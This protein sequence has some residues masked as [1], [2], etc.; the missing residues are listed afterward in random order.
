[1]Q[2]IHVP[3]LALIV[4]GYN[5]NHMLFQ[6]DILALRSGETKAHYNTIQ[7]FSKILLLEAW[8]T[9]SLYDEL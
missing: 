1:M 5:H 2:Y 7:P 4:E 8:L 3:P 6:R 9:K